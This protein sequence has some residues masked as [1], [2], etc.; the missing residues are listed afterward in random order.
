M[1][2]FSIQ[3]F[4]QKRQERQED[5]KLSELTGRDQKYLV[6]VNPVSRGGKALKEGVWLLK[7]L[8]RLGIEHEAF[9]T[10]NPGHAENIVKRWVE[11]VDVVVAVGGDGTINEVVNGIKAV[12]DECQKT[13]AVFPAGTADDYC[14]NVGIQRDR[15]KA[16]EVLLTRNDRR[17]DLIRINDRFAIVQVG[18]GVD[19]EIAYNTLRHKSI[20]IPAYFMAGI[21]IVCVERFKNSIRNLHI[22]SENGVYDDVFLLAVFGNAPLYAR[23]VWWMPEA[24]MDDGILNMSAL[25]PMSPIP[26]WQLF[27][28]CFKKD[29]RSEKILYDASRHFKIE[30]VEESFVQIDGEVYKYA[31][32]EELNVSVVDKAITVRVPVELPEYAPFST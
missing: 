19:A 22:E 17:I 24:R 1:E 23:Y 8:G 4:T 29:Y 30:L 9:I 31:A 16:L 13:L 15:Q 10:E 21:K 5:K 27:F 7:H 26:A 14:H 2:R 18:V 32:G 3:S 20:R 6:V 12:P 28:R 11:R 25:E